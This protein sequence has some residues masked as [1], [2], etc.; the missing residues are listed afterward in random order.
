ML[1]LIIPWANFFQFVN[2]FPASLLC[3]IKILTCSKCLIFSFFYSIRK[4]FK[5][6]LLAGSVR[7]MHPKLVLMIAMELMEYPNEKLH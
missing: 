2:N 5:F 6:P 1:L 4:Y 3:K 7:V